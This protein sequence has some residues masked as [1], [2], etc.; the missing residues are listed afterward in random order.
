MFVKQIDTQGLSLQRG[1]MPRREGG[2][3][4]VETHLDDAGRVELRRR[5]C[6]SLLYW[7]SLGRARTDACTV[8]RVRM[9]GVSRPLGRRAAGARDC[10]CQCGPLSR[11]RIL[12]SGRDGRRYGG[13]V[14]DRVRV[15]EMAKDLDL[16]LTI[17]GCYLG[18]GIVGPW[19]DSTN[20][21]HGCGVALEL[22]AIRDGCR[23]LAGLP[24]RLRFVAL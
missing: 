2:S 9:C 11:P 16:Y 12:L 24:P 1:S 20:Q 22:C 17:P 19:I 7:R 15:S 5:C 8:P 4:P 18:R 21:V 13:P 10:A 3:K 6:T 14:Q 23:P